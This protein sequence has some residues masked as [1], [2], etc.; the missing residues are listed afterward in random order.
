MVITVKRLQACLKIQTYLVHGLI[1]NQVV[2]RILVTILV[3][4]IFIWETCSFEQMVDGVDSESISTLFQPVLEY[5]NHS[6]V[7][8]L[9]IV[10]QVR[11]FL[12]ELMEVALSSFR[13]VGPSARVE[14]CDLNFALVSRVRG[15]SKLTHPV[16]GGLSNRVIDID[17]TVFPYVI[18]FETHFATC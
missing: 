14:Y 1:V 15:Q 12:S 8:I 9:V 18:V 5:V 6:L 10:V 7:H 11:L 16:I 13:V 2:V 17:R 3:N 4:V